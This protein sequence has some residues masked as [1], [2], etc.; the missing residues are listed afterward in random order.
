MNSRIIVIGDVMLDVYVDGSVARISPEA[1]VPVLSFE[2]EFCR[3]GGAA[4]VAI[5]LKGLQEKVTLLGIVG[6]DKFAG[7]AKE[8]AAKSNLEFEA[9]S[10]P[11]KCTIV[12]KRLVSGMHQLLRVDYEETFSEN[13]IL[14]VSEYIERSDVKYEAVVFSDY[15]K[16]TLKEIDKLIPIVQRLFPKAYIIVDPKGDNYSKYMGVDFITPN[17]K[18]FE[19]VMGKWSNESELKHLAREFLV[20]YK[21]KY[22]LLTKSEKGM[23]LFRLDDNELLETKIASNVQQVSDVTGAGDTV[24]A[25]LAY[26]LING[27][28]PEESARI[29]NIAAGIV[30][31][32]RGTSKVRL[33]E[34][35][36]AARD[37]NGG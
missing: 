37:K 24:V 3:L 8:L 1:P 18:E 14:Q 33:S 19:I 12:K 16:G 10:D 26:A 11:H 2:R 6:T 36:I 9:I 29:A 21:V 5:N 4:N 32:K 34:L 13:S 25:S 35:E 15:G 22:L 27:K 20:E 17:E 31:G 23:S 28:S 7:T 30:V